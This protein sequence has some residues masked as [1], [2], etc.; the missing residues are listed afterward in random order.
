[1]P[2]AVLP[3]DGVGGTLVLDPG[4]APSERGTLVYL[5]A[6]DDI[7]G[8]LGR[9][10]ELGGTALSPVIDLGDQG[11]MALLLDTEGNRIALHAS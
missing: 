4:N 3:A 10:G 9:V 5:D 8:A 6:G 2:H 1:V 11:R 7:D